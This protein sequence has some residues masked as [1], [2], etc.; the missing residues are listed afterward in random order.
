MPYP[1]STDTFWDLNKLLAKLDTADLSRLALALR[2]DSALVL[3]C[4]EGHI[5]AEMNVSPQF[6]GPR[7]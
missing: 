4:V 3:E 6:R 5:R 2:A 7:K 1:I